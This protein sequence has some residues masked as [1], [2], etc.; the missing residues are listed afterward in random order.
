MTVRV[1]ESCRA[2]FEQTG[3]GRPRRWCPDCSPSRLEVGG[4]AAAAAWRRLN[5]EAATVFNQARRKGPSC[6]TCD[7]CQKRF[8]QGKGAPRRWCFEC[9]PRV[10]EAG[11]RAVL[12]RRRELGEGAIEAR[13]KRIAR[14]PRICDRCEVRP[15]ITSRHCYCAGC[16]IEALN[17]RVMRRQRRNMTEEELARARERELRRR[18][19]RPEHRLRYNAAFRRQRE[20]IKPLVETGTVRCARGIWCNYAETIGGRTYGGFIHPGESWDLGHADGQSAG[21]PEHSSCNRATASRERK[22]LRKVM[23]A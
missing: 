23:A 10:S 2:Q 4:T 1:C 15:T 5:P 16:R 9:M 18:R 21:G 6:R 22:L 3:P 12:K 14:P 20:E 13:R 19:V 8:L 7:N 11:A 17:E